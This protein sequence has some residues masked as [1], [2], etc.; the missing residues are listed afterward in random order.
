M[1]LHDPADPMQGYDVLGPIKAYRVWRVF[2]EDDE[3][4]RDHALGLMSS[5]TSYRWHRETVVAY[6]KSFASVKGH[7]APSIGCL[8]GIYALK[9]PE[10]GRVVREVTHSTWL[11]QQNRYVFGEVELSGNYIEYAHGYRAQKA[12]ITKIYY[13]PSWSIF[14]DSVTDRLELLYPNVQL[15]PPSPDMSLEPSQTMV[16]FSAAAIEVRKQ[17]EELRVAMQKA[18]DDWYKHQVE[19]Y[20]LISSIKYTKYD[21]PWKAWKP[22][23]KRKKRKDKP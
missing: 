18:A 15:V 5:N 6:C 17:I 16:Y 13:D 4:F 9:A 20:H 7:D 22:W 23:T 21:S 8:C 3:R 10:F 12:K 19:S 1:R 11:Q 2:W 14:T